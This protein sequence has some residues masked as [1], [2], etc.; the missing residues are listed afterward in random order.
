VEKPSAISDQLK[1]AERIADSLQEKSRPTK[2]E[3]LRKKEDL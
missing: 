2:S 3:R 1:A